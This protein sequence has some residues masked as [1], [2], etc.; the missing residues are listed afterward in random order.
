MSNTASLDIPSHNDLAS[1][2]AHTYYEILGVDEKAENESI[3]IAHRKLALKYH[4]DRRNNYTSTT[5]Y[6]N[7]SSSIKT[8]DGADIIY[9]EIQKAWECLR[10]E[11]KRMKYDDSLRRKRERSSGSLIKA[12]AVKLVD[13]KCEICDVEEEEDNDDEVVA[14]KNMVQDAIIIE[15]QQ[16][17]TTQKLYTHPCRCGDY[18]EILEEDLTNSNEDSK[19]HILECQSCSLT[20]HIIL[21]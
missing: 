2:S 7:N 21:I 14:N 20:I 12:Q 1:G 16:T 13:M 19:S 17:M 5:S 11:N 3:K 4:P 6:N 10:D 18:F 8:Q 9:T 15:K